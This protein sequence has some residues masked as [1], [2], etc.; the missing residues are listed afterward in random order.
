MTVGSGKR[1]SKG[2]AQRTPKNTRKHRRTTV[3]LLVDYH[4]Q[5][6]I[7]SDYATTLGAGGMFLQTEIP[8]TRGEIVKLS[9]HIPGGNLLH[10]LDAHVTWYHAARE[11][12]D[13]SIRTP[14]V[15]LKFADLSLTTALARELED[16]LG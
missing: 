2:M 11:E 9:F 5:G 7:H 16:Y 10:G 1:R 6:G 8:M 15:G 3:R 4:A 14:G 12:P 13:G